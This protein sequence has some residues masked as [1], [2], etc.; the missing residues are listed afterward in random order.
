MIERISTMASVRINISLAEDLFQE[1]VREVQPRKRSGFIAESIK[2]SLAGRRA[3]Q[4]AEEYLAA[5]AEIR[6]I[7]HELD[8]VIGDGLD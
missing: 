1:L 5:A 6:E 4:L 2:Q 3:R 8:G 7:G